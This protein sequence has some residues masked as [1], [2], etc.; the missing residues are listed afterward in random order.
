MSL[1]KNRQERVGSYKKITFFVCY[2]VFN[3]IYTYKL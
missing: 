2:P 3:C 1:N